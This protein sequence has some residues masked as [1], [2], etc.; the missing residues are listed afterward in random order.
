MYND[1]VA[2]LGGEVSDSGVILKE[3]LGFKIQYLWQNIYF[4]SPTKLFEKYWRRK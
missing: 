4:P 3:L 1:S 2:L